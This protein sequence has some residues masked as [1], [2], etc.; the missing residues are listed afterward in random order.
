M[1]QSYRDLFEFEKAAEVYL[2]V[3]KKHPQN[4]VA[5]K[6]AAMCYTKLQQA[7]AAETML[8]HLDSMKLATGEDLLL[9][10][11]AQKRNRKYKEALQTYKK[12][13]TFFPGNELVNKYIDN[14]DWAHKINRD[15][16]LFQLK[17][18]QVLT[19]SFL[20]LHLVFMIIPSFTAHLNRSLTNTPK[21]T[22][23]IIRHT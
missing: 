19:P 5:Y 9:L 3:I 21:S 6:G 11:D 23:G 13:S 10:A 15:S 8:L 18:A 4:Y 22:A 20:T 17:N 7:K 12:H 2:D 14:K 16:S 1:A